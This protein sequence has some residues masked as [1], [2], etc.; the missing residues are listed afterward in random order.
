MKYIRVVNWR[1]Y[2]HYQK[3]TPPW[4]KLHFNLLSSY[5]FEGLSDS[6]KWHVVGLFLLAGR[7]GNRIPLDVRWIAK[8]IG[9]KRT[10]DFTRIFASGLLEECTQDATPPRARARASTETEVESETQTESETESEGRGE[11]DSWMQDGADQSEEA[12][13][14]QSWPDIQAEAGIPG[15]TIPDMNRDDK[16][17]PNGVGFKQLK[18]TVAW[19]ARRHGGYVSLRALLVERVREHAAGT[20][21]LFSL[22]RLLGDAKAMGDPKDK[23]LTD[24]ER[25]KI[26]D[27][28]GPK[29][30]S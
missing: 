1:T 25:Q 12:R 13:L 2:Q 10:I 20:R 29:E 7:T 18:E 14:I 28:W 11:D 30:D 26:R 4:I 24:A 8:E 23:P 9:A 5:A 19:A 15:H 22:K 6:C 21:E 3:R 17:K 27:L 16:H